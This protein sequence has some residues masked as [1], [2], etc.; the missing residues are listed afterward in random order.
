MKSNYIVL[1]SIGL[2]LIIGLYMYMNSQKDS[3]QTASTGS[4]IS[5][6]QSANETS[7]AD[8]TFINGMIEHHMGAIAMAS[9]AQEKSQREEIT[10][11]ADNI[12]IAQEKEINMM[13]QWKKDWYSDTEKVEISTEGH[14]TS[15]MQELGEADEQF[16]L[17]FI[18]AMTEHHEGAI[19]M[20]NEILKKT[21]KEEIKTLAQN[22]IRD[23]TAEI[24][25][26]KE[27]KN[28]WYSQ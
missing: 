27:W 13:Y 7:D 15:M 26:M 10:K 21:E 19:D 6:E 3:S 18:Q 16:D 20:A 12:I 25:Q 14:G 1:G 11:L 2:L 9:E 4:S 8:K 5:T 28:S 22:I 17:R 24:N 23:Q